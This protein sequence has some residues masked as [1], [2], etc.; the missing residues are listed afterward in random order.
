MAI[1]RHMNDLVFYFAIFIINVTLSNFRFE[2]ILTR[3]SSGQIEAALGNLTNVLAVHD[4]GR[5]RCVGKS[6][7][8]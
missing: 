2:W 4:N 3:E 5:V 7:I 1:L 8:I 6:T